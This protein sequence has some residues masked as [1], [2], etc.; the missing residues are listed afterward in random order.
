MRLRRLLAA[1]WLVLLPGFVLVT[2]FFATTA[3]F[4]TT[5]GAS[6][7]AT[8]TV[9]TLADGAGD[10][11][12]SGSCTLRAAIAAAAPGDTIVFAPALAGGTITLSLSLIHI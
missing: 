11:S 6:S 9:D 5:A 2:V 4:V 8:L 12:T 1:T 3:F 7:Y 10:C